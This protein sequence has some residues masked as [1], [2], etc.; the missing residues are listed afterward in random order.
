MQEARSTANDQTRLSTYGVPT[1]VVARNAGFGAG[2]YL[3]GAAAERQTSFWAKADTSSQNR[4]RS[5]V[6]RKL[7]LLIWRMAVCLG[8]MGDLPIT[9]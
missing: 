7:R 1:A 2:A 3:T 5:T 8:C 4:R 9:R 6:D